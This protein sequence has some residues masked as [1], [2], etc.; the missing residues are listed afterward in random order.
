[1]FREIGTKVQHRN[2]YIH[3]KI[4]D[5]DGKP[6]WVAEGRRVWELKYGEL[7]EGDRVFHTNGDRTDNRPGNLAKV[8][9]NNVKFIFLKKS[10]VLYTPTTRLMSRK[11][12]AAGRE[13]VYVDKDK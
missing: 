9:F 12:I 10:R 7:E 11:P 5:D 3:V 2:G 1:M 6:K 8:H 4:R 13:I